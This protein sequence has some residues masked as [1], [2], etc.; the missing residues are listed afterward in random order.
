MFDLVAEK[1][2]KINYS[3]RSFSI[4]KEKVLNIPILSSVVDFIYLFVDLNPQITKILETTSYNDIVN[5]QNTEIK[6][7]V[8]LTWLNNVRSLDKFLESVNKKI[9]FKG[10]FI[11]RVETKEQ[12]FQRIIKKIPKVIFYPYYCLD[13]IITRILPKW[14]LTRWLY[15]SL[16]KRN[17]KVLSL[18][19]I[20]GMFVFY[21]FKINYLKDIN[22][23]THFVLE[24]INIPSK[25]CKPSSGIL[26]KMERIGKNGKIFYIYKLRTMHP[27]SEYI[28]D[29]LYDL[30]GSENGDKITDDFRVASWGKIL[31]KYWIDELP[32][33]INLLKGD[34]KIVGVRP[35][36]T[37]KFNL[38]PLK[39]Q[40]LRTSIKPGLIP[41][42]YADLPTTFDELL[43]S[44]EKYIL[45]YKNKPITTDIKFFFKCFYNIL[46]QRARSA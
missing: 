36:S 27:Y 32:M 11:C 8:N 19:H 44:E 29:F 22:G 38:Y 41:P 43:E 20:M 1:L 46:F 6:N 3:S 21:G 25:K 13:F 24:K 23:I 31:R 34:I 40:K 35:L 4:N 30:N 42:F 5:I 7:I 14:G 26:F 37:I 15:Y 2:H 12:R 16:T 18:A 9:P 33:L 28:Q 39:L 45:A 17:E 10:I